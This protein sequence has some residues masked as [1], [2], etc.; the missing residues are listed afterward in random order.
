MGQSPR[1][2]CLLLLAAAAVSLPA[3]PAAQGARQGDAAAWLYDPL[4]V[5]AIDLSA[6]PP[7]LDSLRSSPRSYVDAK[8][9][10]HEG[11]TRR[12]AP[13]RRLETQGP[14]SFRDLD[15]KAAFRIKLDYSVKSRSSW[16]E[17]PDAQQHG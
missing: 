12:S 1:K 16:A 10:L 7:A 2:L 5:N 14:G 6:T 4:R 15:G 13:I 17:G 11:A 9:T 3:Q 8:L